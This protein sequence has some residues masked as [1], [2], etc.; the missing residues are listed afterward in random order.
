MAFVEFRRPSMRSDEG[1]L[2]R[3]DSSEAERHA[4]VYDWTREP[5]ESG[6][7]LT[8]NRVKRQRELPITVV[9][10]SAEQGG[11]VRD[12]H[13]QAWTR[14]RALADQDPPLLFEVTTTP[15]FYD[16]M[17]IVSIG[18]PR[19]PDQGDVMVADIA[20]RQLTYSQTDTAQNLADAA[21]DP[22]LG[23]VDLGSQGLG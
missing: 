15:E 23:E 21:Q 4:A 20:F 8:D 2:F 12:R 22:G 18:W 1:D 19:S 5:I 9:V 7:E 11:V 3:F 6:A 14:L 16:D 13:I 10:S 17:V